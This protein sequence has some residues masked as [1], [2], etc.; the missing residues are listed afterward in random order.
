MM[1]RS[2]KSKVKYNSKLLY[3]TVMLSYYF[4]RVEG[5]SVCDVE[6]DRTEAGECGLV[7]KEGKA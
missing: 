6:N 5:A 3:L 4:I 7:A 2:L 1:I